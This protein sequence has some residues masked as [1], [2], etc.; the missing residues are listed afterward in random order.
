VISIH[1]PTRGAIGGFVIGRVCLFCFKLSGDLPAGDTLSL[2]PHRIANKNLEPLAA[3]SGRP[4]SGICIPV[5][6]EVDSW[7]ELGCPVPISFFR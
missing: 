7:V 1:A 5:I 4:Y 6:G 2:K 3:R